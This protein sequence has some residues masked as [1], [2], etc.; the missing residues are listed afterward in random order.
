MA[1]FIFYVGTG[2]VGSSKR[3][4]HEIPDE[5]LEGLSENERYEAVQEAFEE[6]IWDN[7]DASWDE[8][9]N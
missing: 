3:H 9:P 2:V 8:V 4:T 1:K 5:D 6:W 7:I